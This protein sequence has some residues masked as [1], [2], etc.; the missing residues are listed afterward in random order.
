MTVLKSRYQVVATNVVIRH[1]DGD[2]VHHIENVCKRMLAE[3]SNYLLG[4][5]SE[6]T[7][8]DAER[9]I[10]EIDSRYQLET[11]ISKLGPFIVPEI[12]ELLQLQ[13]QVSAM[14][15]TV[16][17][18]FQHCYATSCLM[19]SGIYD[20]TSFRAKVQKHVDRADDNQVMRAQIESEVRAR[21][22]AEMRQQFER[23]RQSSDDRMGM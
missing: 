10:E 15:T 2:I 9:L 17:A 19:E 16:D 11:N 7:K 18:A 6:L 8:Y 20:H 3:D 22:E 1:I 5:V 12:K 4:A 14:V 21:V 13:A 23:E